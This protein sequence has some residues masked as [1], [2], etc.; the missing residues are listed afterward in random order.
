[1]RVKNI[2]EGSIIEGKV[3]NITDYGAFID[4]GGID[5]LVHVT[6]I[7][8]TKIN[9]P[10]E[11]LELNSNIKVKVLK[12]D[13]ELSRLSLG[14]KQLTDNPWDNVQDN[15][16][17]N[18]WT[19][20]SSNH[21]SFA[22]IFLLQDITNMKMPMLKFFMKYVL[23]YVPIIGLSWWA[24]DMPFLKRYTKK[25]LEKNPKLVGKDVKE[26]KRALKHYSLYPV[27]VFSFAEGT[28]FTVKKHQNQNSPFDNLLKPKEGGLATALSLVNKID[29][30]IDFTIKFDS[31]KRS[32]WDYL[33]GRM[34]SAK[35][36]IKEI[37]IPKKF[38][39][40]DLLNNQPLR[41]EFK[42]WVNSLWVEK[43]LL[44]QGKK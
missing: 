1:M 18:G 44:L 6:D 24:L 19:I 2:K 30:L 28:R 12:F 41:S 23:I 25:Q 11:I 40:E 4:L 3:K 21:Q 32:F 17:S 16:K 26:M 38:L 43:D 37:K 7:S 8:W 35:I 36:I 5:G 22:D 34:N 39:N 20:A 15:I 10:S 31:Q 14:I 42:E 9:S 29:S 27:T 33:C 13:E